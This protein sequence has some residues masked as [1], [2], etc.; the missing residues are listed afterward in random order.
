MP[1]AGS[2]VVLERV[3]GENLD[4]GSRPTL[5]FSAL[6]HAVLQQIIKVGKGSGLGMGLQGSARTGQAGG[7][8]R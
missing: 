1:L 4:G 2:V 7:C 3:S 5:R 8:A 6:P